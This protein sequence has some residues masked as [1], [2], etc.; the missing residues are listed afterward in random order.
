MLLNPQIERHFRALSAHSDVGSALLAALKPLGE[1]EVRGGGAQ[2]AAIYCITRNIVFCA[3]SGMR[4]TYWRLRPADLDIA[5]ATGAQ[6]TDLGSD[7]V[8]FS[9]FRHDWPRPD[10]AHWALRAYDFACLD[11]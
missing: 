1:Y 8:S 3:A 6:R 7:W 10:L 11:Q 4:E 9:L 5:L 2:F